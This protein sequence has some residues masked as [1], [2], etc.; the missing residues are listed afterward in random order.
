[1]RGAARMR[2]GGHGGAP[3]AAAGAAAQTFGTAD[4]ARILRLPPV[5]VRAIVRAGLCA[6]AR[7]GRALEFS[8]QDLLLLRTAHGLL[9][10]KVPPRR[11]RTA[12]RELSRQ[13]P[14]GQPL[15]GVRIYA[16]GRH[17]V[18]R[19]GRTAWQPDSGQAVFTFDVDDL[20][21]KTGVVV[22]VPR[23]RAGKVPPPPEAITANGWL[24][25]AL[26]LEEVDTKAAAVAY[27]QA[28][29][30]APE[31]T[32]AY[33]NLGRLLHEAGDVS[34]ARRLYGEALR[35]APDDPVAHY[36]MALALEDQGDPTG[37]THYYHR[38]LEIDPDFA[39]AHF[40][41]GRLLDKLGERTQALR[42]LL[43]YKKLTG[44]P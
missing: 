43:A 35:R 3:A 31:M 19:D 44:R 26:A 27:R 28:L 30:L 6:P 41:L 16:D 33:I 14:A 5:R 25:R 22:K 34:E 24:D 17:V 9:Q 40:N 39:D 11:V 37:A 18:V 8:F 36:D 4:A 21:R 38:A 20:A 1:M 29:Q 12:L 23:S 13:L 2:T 10:A 32:D 7:R 15:S 42:H